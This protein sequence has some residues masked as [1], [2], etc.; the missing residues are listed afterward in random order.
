MAL[1]PWLAKLK[2][3]KGEPK[4]EEKKEGKPS[5]KKEMS[6]SEHKMENAKFKGKKS[7]RDTLKKMK[8]KK[9]H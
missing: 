4:G 6:E 5:K 9:C 8:G 7:V 3:E 2:G 1:P